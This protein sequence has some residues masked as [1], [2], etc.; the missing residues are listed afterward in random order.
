MLTDE[1]VQTALDA[2]T[3]EQVAELQA[4]QPP[5]PAEDVVRSYRATITGPVQVVPA[6]AWDVLPSMYIVQIGEVYRIP[7]SWLAYD[8]GVAG[9]RHP[10]P[11]VPDGLELI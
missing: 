7:D 5:P 4:L 9:V 3:P 8:S 1:E 11:V 6:H 2:L 10:E